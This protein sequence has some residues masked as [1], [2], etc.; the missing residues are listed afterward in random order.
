MPLGIRPIHRPWP[1]ESRKSRTVVR[2]KATACSTSDGRA[3]AARASIA[4]RIQWRRREPAELP[5][6]MPQP[7]RAAANTAGGRIWTT[8]TGRR[9]AVI[10][11]KSATASGRPRKCVAEYAR[12]TVRRTTTQIAIR[13]GKPDSGCGWDLFAVMC[14]P[15]AQVILPGPVLAPDAVVLQEGTPNRRCPLRNAVAT[16]QQRAL[17]GRG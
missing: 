2:P 13:L 4:R 9:L 6:R 16:C 1:Q 3:Y 17:K 12:Y 5:P 8:M 10:A 7:F 15:V 14:T 11:R